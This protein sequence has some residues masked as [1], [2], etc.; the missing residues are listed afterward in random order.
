MAKA[1]TGAG[2]GVVNAMAYRPEHAHVS[3]QIE[4]IHRVQADKNCPSAAA[5]EPA[6]PPPAAA[7]PGPARRAR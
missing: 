2:G 1:S 7:K 3:G 6:A 4:A 5:P